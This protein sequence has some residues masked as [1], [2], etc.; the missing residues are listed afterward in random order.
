[1]VCSFFSALLLPVS[2]C[3]MLNAAWLHLPRWARFISLR[4]I[5]FASDLPLPHEFLRIHISEGMFMQIVYCII[6]LDETGCEI[7]LVS[8]LLI[9]S[10]NGQKSSSVYSC[11]QYR[12]QLI[13]MRAIVSFC[14]CISVAAC[15]L[16]SFPFQCWLCSLWF[17]CTVSC[18]KHWQPVSQ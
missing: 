17:V 3:W 4:M 11:Y 16:Y 15:K 12:Q 5:S 14:V 8:K 1:M 10:V 6:N 18:S 9:Q 7:Q 2:W 13:T